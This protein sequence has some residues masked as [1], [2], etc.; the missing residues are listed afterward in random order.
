MT[1]GAATFTLLFHISYL[2]A[3][4]HFAIAPDDAAAGESSE[5]EKPNETHVVLM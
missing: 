3:R 1:M 5:A 2:A 4:G